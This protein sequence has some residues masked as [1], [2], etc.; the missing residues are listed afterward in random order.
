MTEKQYSIKYLLHRHKKIYLDNIF[1][2]VIIEIDQLLINTKK[3]FG[4]KRINWLGLTNLEGFDSP[5]H[6]RQNVAQ[7]HKGQTHCL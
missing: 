1:K 3:S 6:F 4:I 7:R 5:L 2:S